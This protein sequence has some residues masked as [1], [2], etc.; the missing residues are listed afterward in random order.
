MRS[1]K[2]YTGVDISISVIVLFTFVSIIATLSYSFNS[3]AKE[4]ELKSKAT[5]IAI[6]QIETMKNIN[7]AD[8]ED[9]SITNGN[10]QYLPTDTTKQVEEV[11]GEENRGFFRRVTI[12]DYAD[13]EPEKR[14]GF[15]KKITVQIQYRFKGKAQT[16]ELSTIVSKES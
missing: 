14:A 15:V 4:I 5:E 7:F 1:E 16:V 6:T 12:E 9:R 10:S 8:I 11:E 13:S 3:S 2:G